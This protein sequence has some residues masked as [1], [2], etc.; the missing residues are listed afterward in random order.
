MLGVV[1]LVNTSSVV[2]YGEQV[3]DLCVNA[4]DVLGNDAAIAAHPGP[5]AHP[6]VPPPVEAE[7]LADGGKDHV[8]SKR[9]A[10][11]KPTT[12]KSQPWRHKKNKTRL[13]SGVR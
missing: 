4:I 1:V 13:C 6:V 2:Q 7:L 10:A 9:T 8:I 5:V 3:C 12:K 11:A